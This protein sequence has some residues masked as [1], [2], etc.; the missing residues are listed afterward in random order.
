MGRIREILVDIRPEY[1]FFE[2]IDFEENVAMLE[3]D[4]KWKHIEKRLIDM[5]KMQDKIFDSLPLKLAVSSVKRQNI[6]QKK[7]KL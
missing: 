7:I 2:D 1:D 6:H 3:G 4:Y 5:T